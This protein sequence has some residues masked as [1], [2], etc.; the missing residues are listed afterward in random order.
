MSLR[1]QRRRRSL[2]YLCSPA[3][4][5]RHL[6][7]AAGL[8]SGRGSGSLAYASQRSTPTPPP[9]PDPN[10]TDNRQTTI[11]CLKRVSMSAKRSSYIFI[12]TVSHNPKMC[13][14]KLIIYGAHFR[15][16]DYVENRGKKIFRN[17]SNTI[18]NNIVPLRQI[19]I[20][21]R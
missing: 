9:H 6:D 17:D 14:T 5:P 15:V 11:Q 18:K 4:Y 10:I 16:V 19:R 2:S 20:K 12:S 21:S 13:A 8:A 3:R 7:C 1:H